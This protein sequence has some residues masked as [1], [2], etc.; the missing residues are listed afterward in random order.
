[1]IEA[2]IIHIGPSFT[3]VVS[4]FEATKRWKA[5][6]DYHYHDSE[7]LS[8][9]R[10][11]DEA[12]T[13][14]LLEMDETDFAKI[15]EI[16]NPLINGTRANAITHDETWNDGDEIPSTSTASYTT[17]DA[18]RKAAMKSL[19]GD[20]PTA[21]VDDPNYPNEPRRFLASNCTM[22]LVPPEARV[23]DLTCRFWGV[24][25]LLSSLRLVSGKNRRLWDYW[26]GGCCNGLQDE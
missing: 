21:H 9:L 3:S 15:C 16:R 10:Q 6:F 24:A 17:W 8:L 4:S 2:E 22:G 11:L 20:S 5:S 26:Q 18:N 13:S 25:M 19:G 1:L 14:P 12:Y 7:G 23:G